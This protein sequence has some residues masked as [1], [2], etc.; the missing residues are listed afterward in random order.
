MDNPMTGAF[1]EKQQTHESLELELQLLRKKKEEAIIL[2]EEK[3]RQGSAEQAVLRI[4]EELPQLA[5][6][7]E[8]INNDEDSEDEQR[9]GVDHGRDFSKMEFSDC[10]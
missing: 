8:L 3:N 10:L 2:G 5:Q 7:L 1:Q 6:M 4:R 9:G